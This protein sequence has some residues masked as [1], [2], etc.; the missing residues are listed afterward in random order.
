MSRSTNR[1]HR[2]RLLIVVGF[3]L[4][5]GVLSWVGWSELFLRVKT[6]PG[7]PIVL[8]PVLLLSWPAHE[9]G[10]VIAG[11]GAGA[12]ALCPATAPMLALFIF[13]AAAIWLPLSLLCLKKPQVVYAVVIQCAVLALLFAFFWEF[14]NG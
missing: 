12:N 8:L 14:G 11:S 1:F 13:Q 10:L 6:I 5:W 4:L 3:A 9:I 2:V 7:L